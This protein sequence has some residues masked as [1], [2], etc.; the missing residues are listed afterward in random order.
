M[1]RDSALPAT[2]AEKIVTRSAP[3]M[4]AGLGALGCSFLLAQLSNASELGIALRVALMV[5]GLVLAGTSVIIRY[6]QTRWEETES[7][8]LTGAVLALGGLAALIG[9]WSMNK[10]W[11]SARM[12]LELLVGVALAGGVVVMLPRGWRRAVV[13][14][15]VIFHFGGILSVVTSAPLPNGSQ[16]WI[17]TQLFTRVYQPYLES[18]Y[19]L[20]AYHFYSPDPGP[21]Y[22][23]RFYIQYEDDTTAM[24]EVPRRE[25]FRTRLE[26]QRRLALAD[27]ASTADGSSPDLE[28]ISNRRNAGLLYNPPIILAPDLAP[29]FQF[30]RPTA[31]GLRMLSSY[32]RHVAENSFSKGDPPKP[33]RRVKV[34]CMI[35][36]I[37]TAQQYEL[38]WE[39][40][41]PA[42]FAPMYFGTWDR[43]GNL[44]DSQDP[45]LFWMIPVFRRAKEGVPMDGHV[46]TFEETE[47]VDLLETHAQF[48]K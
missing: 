33:M 46:P 48:T 34:Y 42:T 35:H 14:L 7:R 36:H 3:T 1:T 29:A 39:A 43:E 6:R 23:L 21:A 28:M 31:H 9:Y 41:D 20:N 18:I 17:A 45:L 22:L 44:L 30:R 24:L 27:R 38:G 15:L 25:D 32:V 8:L 37:I 12:V 5:T 4:L 13:S 47:L 40:D 26:F 2:W 10:E 19:Q 11:D 16:S